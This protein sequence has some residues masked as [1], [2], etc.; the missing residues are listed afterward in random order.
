LVAAKHARHEDLLPGF[1]FESGEDFAVGRGEL[2]SVGVNV[3]REEFHLGKVRR[4]KKAG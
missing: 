1:A 2:A 4:E 3:G